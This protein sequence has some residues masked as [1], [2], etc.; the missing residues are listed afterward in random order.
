[1]LKVIQRLAG[2]VRRIAQSIRTR[3]SNHLI[4]DRDYEKKLDPR[5][6]LQS[7]KSWMARALEGEELRRIQ[8]LSGL[9]IVNV[10]P[11][12]PP[13]SPVADDKVTSSICSAAVSPNESDVLKDALLQTV[14]IVNVNGKRGIGELESLHAMACGKKRFPKEPASNHEPSCPDKEEAAATVVVEAGSAL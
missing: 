10:L 13:D 5:S 2:K 4:M 8:V 3:I 14:S 11:M 6:F 1:M 9:P 12:T 7:P